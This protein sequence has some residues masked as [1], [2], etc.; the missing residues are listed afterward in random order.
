MRRDV[1]PFVPTSTA[2]G[3]HV[4]AIVNDGRWVAQCRCGSAQVVDPE[5]S[6]FFCVECLNDYA[7]GQWVTIRFPR[8]RASIERL[9]EAR[10]DRRTMNWRPGESLSDLRRENR[11]R[12][13]E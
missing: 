7:G 10:P 3:E 1:A 13:V 5:H 4:E 6:M 12:G 11:Q 2:V 9:L 8:G